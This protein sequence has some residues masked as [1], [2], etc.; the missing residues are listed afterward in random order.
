MKNNEY[1][2][3][4]KLYVVPSPIGNLEDVT[5]RSIKILNEVDYILCEDTRH[6]ILFLNKFNIKTKLISYY[7]EVENQKKDKVLSDILNGKKVALISDAGMPGI[8]DPGNILISYLIENNIEIV[9]IPGASASITAMV[10]SGFD[11]THFI[12]YGFLNTKKSKKESE[13]KTIL[14]YNMPVIIYESPN[15]INETLEIISNIDSKRRVSI[16][17]EMTKIFEETIRGKAIDLINNFKEKGEFVL[18]IDK[19]SDDI[20]DFKDLDLKEHFEYYI[21]K[22]YSKKDAIKQ[23]A[24]DLNVPKNDIYKLF[25]N[26]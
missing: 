15:R 19:K 4:G 12:F 17:R 23:I 13:L 21:L 24:K 8:S 26:D 1:N 25:T 14:N 11:T 3:I 5:Y 10:N 18:V 9:T 6:S 7:K 22:G 20:L 16:S 2:K